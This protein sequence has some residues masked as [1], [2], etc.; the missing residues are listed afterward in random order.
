MAL[1]TT[2]ELCTAEE[3]RSMVEPKARTMDDIFSAVDIPSLGSA[4]VICG[5]FL[6]K[7]LLTTKLELLLPVNC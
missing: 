7:T 6:M 4:Y 1:L 3:K 2:V 5:R